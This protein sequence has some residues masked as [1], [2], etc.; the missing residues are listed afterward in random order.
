[1]YFM[2]LW[3]YFFVTWNFNILL[4]VLLKWDTCQNKTNYL[5][6]LISL[7]PHLFPD[8]CQNK[9]S[10]PP[11]FNFPTPPSFSILTQ[12]EFSNVKINKIYLLN[13]IFLLPLLFP[14]W[15]SANFRIFSPREYLFYSSIKFS[16]YP[17]LHE[18]PVGDKQI[19][20]N[21]FFNLSYF[22]TASQSFTLVLN[23]VSVQERPD[24]ALLSPKKTN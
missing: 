2:L 22:L 4:I 20:A 8:T 16:Q 9:K 3:L 13:L 11:L 7:D 24:F 15:L 6:Y 10:L 17:V 5:L 14:F 12:R 19:F 21:F 18:I 23:L 1:M